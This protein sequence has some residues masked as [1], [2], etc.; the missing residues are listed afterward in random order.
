MICEH[1][2]AADAHEALLD[3]SELFTVSLRGDDI[4][5]FDTRGDQ[6]LSAASEIPNFHVLESL[7]KMRVRESVQLQ[8]VLAMYEQEMDQNRSM[9]SYQKFKTMIGRHK[10]QM[11]RTR[12]F[13]ARNER[14]ETGVLV[15]GHKRRKVSV[16]RTSGEC[17]Q[18]RA[19]GQCARGDSCSVCHG[20]HR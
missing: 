1:F 11:I 7:C 14:V 20:N 5:C 6:A 17:Y 10:D 4:Q 18:W 9:P 15:E 3:L 12:N 8:T 13:K 16:E 2:R 19:T